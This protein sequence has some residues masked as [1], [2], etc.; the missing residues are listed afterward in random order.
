[1]LNAAEPQSAL[2]ER[3]KGKKQAQGSQASMGPS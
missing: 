1:V 2:V 3:R